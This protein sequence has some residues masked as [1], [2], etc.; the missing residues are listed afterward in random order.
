MN[1]KYI[2]KN[3]MFL[4][5]IGI[6]LDVICKCPTLIKAKQKM[7][8]MMKDQNRVKCLGN[9]YPTYDPSWFNLNTKSN[10]SGSTFYLSAIPPNPH[11]FLILGINLDKLFIIKYVRPFLFASDFLEHCKKEYELGRIHCNSI[12]KKF[13]KFFY[14]TF[15]I[16]RKRS[17]QLLCLETNERN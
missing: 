4:P 16:L 14:L 8:K 5:S 9:T 13:D 11:L 15:N 17:F 2:V 12:K 7:I 10:V 1:D 3:K 6:H